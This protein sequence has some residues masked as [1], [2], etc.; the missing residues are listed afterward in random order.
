MT[1]LR[2]PVRSERA[3]DRRN[4]RVWLRADLIAVALITLGG[5]ALRFLTLSQ[6]VW[7]DEAVTVRD[8][9]GSFAHM[10]GSVGHTELSPP[11]YFA[12]LWLW[13]HLFGSTTVDLRAL[14]ALAGT[15]MI[16][17]AFVAAKRIF[18]SRTGIV[19]A[20]L[21]ASSS[22]L[23]YYSQELR[24]YAL[25]ALLCGLGFLAFLDALEDRGRAALPRWAALSL[26]AFATQ[27]YAWLAVGPEA[28]ILLVQAR[29]GRIGLRGPLVA[30]GT[31]GAGAVALLAFAESQY[32][33]SYRY[34]GAQLSSPF[35]GVHFSAS[36]AARG[37]VVSSFVQ[38]L[39]IG[40]GG[41]A[42]ALMSA[43]V[44]IVV[45][46]ALVVLL[47]HPDDGQRRR[48]MQLLLLAAVGALVAA[49][50]FGLGLPIQGRYL[51]PLSLP[52]TLAIAYALSSPSAGR[53]GL[54]LV[55]A[56]CA[57]WLVVGIVS[58]TDSRFSA[59]ED[60]RGAARAL[61]VARTDRLVAIDDAWDLLPLRVYRP[62]ATSPTSRVVEVTEVDLISMPS[63]GLMFPSGGDHPAP[64]VPS[65]GQLPGSLVLRRIVR[66]SG[67]VVER[68][69]SPTP[70]SVRLGPAGGTFSDIWRFLLERPG[71]RT[72][73]L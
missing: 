2:D 73:G 57:L 5:G 72:S 1:A 34:V 40:P 27:Y 30:V 71:A 60:T 65:I 70:V 41:P 17:V 14:S 23:L 11:F 53:I 52:A 47:R 24:A 12:C 61:G 42:K 68:F 64:V 32:A 56:L 58:F 19:A 21:V 25:L 55:A 28:L 26:L 59:R 36:W 38:Q 3:S 44:V 43:A 54:A 13:R 22:M 6:S 50:W 39:A 46:A 29:R 51:L 49:A 66:G 35:H 62:A 8:V 45:I 9:S 10:L 15:L 18:G 69:T 37:N 7:F 48:A 31:V 4:A 16:P 33:S 20:A 63:S 67:F